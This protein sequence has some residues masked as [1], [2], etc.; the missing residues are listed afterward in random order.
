M[1]RI[2]SDEISEKYFDKELK[3]E[4]WLQD[5][6]DLGKIVFLVVRDRN[7]FQVTCKGDLIKEVRA[8]PKE[9][10]ISAKG[11]IKGNEEVMNG[12]E[13]LLEE[14]KVLNKAET[15]L[16][17]DPTGRTPADLDTRLNSRI[18]DLRRRDVT[19]TF[20]NRTRVMR[21]IRDFYY[22][23]GFIE[24]NTPKIVRAGMEGGATLFKLDYFGT[25]AYLAQSPQLY[26]QM[27]MGSGFD[28]VFETA[29][30]FRAEESATRRHLSEF[31]SVD[32]EIAFVEMGDVLDNLEGLCNRVLERAA[33]IK[34]KEFPRLEY[35]EALSMVGREEMDRKA[36]VEISEKVDDDLF[37]ILNYPA[38]E[39]PFYIMKK[40]ERTNSFDLF[41]KGLEISS[42]GQREH[43]Y[44]VLCDNIKESGLNL[45]DF[46]YYLEPFRYGMPPHG[47]YGLGFDRFIQA[48]MG[49]D[50]V[51]ET[52]LFPRDRF[53]CH[54]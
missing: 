17:L 23:E 25:P 4:G 15:P 27:L 5:L 32:A 45:E 10:I 16:P 50:N 42:G 34:L 8:I 29:P 3:L 49:L 52:V 40:G 7:L 2:Y 9:S 44:P 41:Y 1:L 13:L 46:K 14:V 43:R 36:E 6:R 26:K 47:G 11:V 48:M 39:K 38:E 51:R 28:K 33:G 35:D 37:F 24:V 22:D 31:I 54:P 19:E 21:E 12:W 20:R 53:R 18:I 30:A